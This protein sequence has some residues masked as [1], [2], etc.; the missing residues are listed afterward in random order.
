[1]EC[2]GEKERGEGLTCRQRNGGLAVLSL[3]E[4]F[5]VFKVQREKVVGAK[6]T[7]HS[8]QA[9]R[10]KERF[11]LKKILGLAACTSTILYGLIRI[12]GR[13]SGIHTRFVVHAVHKGSSKKF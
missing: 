5:K 2:T 10:E 6:H 9:Q 3:L 13:D 7:Q 11:D 8:A 12:P 4:V 1:M